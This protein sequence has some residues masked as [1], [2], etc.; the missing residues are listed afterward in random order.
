MCFNGCLNAI[1]YG[2]FSFRRVNK[3]VF[4]HESEINSARESFIL[5][6]TEDSIWIHGINCK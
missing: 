1:L 2:Y 5:D 6:H 3:E 4:Y